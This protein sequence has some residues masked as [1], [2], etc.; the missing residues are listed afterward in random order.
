MSTPQPK[1]RNMNSHLTQVLKCALRTMAACCG[2][3]ALSA[4]GGGGRGGGPVLAGNLSSA[5]GDATMVAYFQATH[6]VSLSAT[7]SMSNNYTFQLDQVP[8]S[9]TTTFKGMAN[10][11]STTDTV[12]LTQN[13]TTIGSS[14]DTSYALLNPFVPLGKVNSTGTP[15]AE[16][17]SSTP[18]PMTLTTGTSGSFANVTYYHDSTKAIMDAMETSTYTVS[19]NTPTS[20]LYC[21]QS[22]ISGTTAQGTADGMGNGTETDCYTVTAAGVATVVSVT[23]AV[24]GGTLKFQ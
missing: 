23:I 7:D 3:L 11:Y 14:V 12:T 20:L 1:E 22:I 17:T 9:G 24:P 15:Y 10:A 6:H 21:I 2:L 5:P 19:A 13:G 8:G 4:C 16:V 18:I